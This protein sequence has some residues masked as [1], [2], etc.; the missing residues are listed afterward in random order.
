METLKVK[1]TFIEEVLGTASSNP[2]IHKEFIAS[3][4]EDAAKI[5]DE[6]AS[7]GAEAV[8]EKS[9]TI[10]P[11][12]NDKPFVWDYQIKG[13]FKDAC[14]MLRRATDTKS[15]KLTAHKKV[16]DGCIFAQPRKILLTLPEGAEMGNC[17]RPLRASTAQGER[18]ALANSET[19]PEGTTI[20]FSIV[21]LQP[22]LKAVV[23]EWLDYGQLRGLGQWRNSGK[24]RF[25]WAKC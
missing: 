2:E 3:K 14:S 11:K 7:I 16:I 8:E 17:Q 25:D 4:A 22:K 15:S 9:K 13:F 21:L 6:V 10:F 1:L 19:V 20:E 24:G 18:I 12:E 5:E 23:E